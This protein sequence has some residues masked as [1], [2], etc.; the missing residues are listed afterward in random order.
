MKKL[1]VC[2][3]LALAIV[4]TL[5]VTASAAIPGVG[6]FV[7]GVEITESNASDV[8][9]DG[10]VSY[11]TK[12]RTLT[13]N[14]ASITTPYI[15]E[16]YGEDLYFGIYNS[17]TQVLRIELK[18]ENTIDLDVGPEIDDVVTGIFSNGSLEFYGEGSL[19][20]DGWGG[21]TAMNDILVDGGEYE[22]LM[23]GFSAVNGDATLKNATASASYGL[24]IAPTGDIRLENMK[25]P[26][27]G[28]DNPFY[29]E[30]G[31]ITVLD[32]E[33]VVSACMD[34]CL[35]AGE[36]GGNIN[37]KNSSLNLNSSTIAIHTAAGKVIMEGVT[38]KITAR[39]EIGYGIM[40]LGDVELSGC[41]LEI[42]ARAT[43]DSA[44]CIA[45]MGDI[46]IKESKLT[47]DAR[48]VKEP[49]TAIGNPMEGGDILVKESELD[50]NTSGWICVG[51][52]GVNIK[53]DDSKVKIMATAGTSEGDGPGG[54]MGIYTEQGLVTVEGGRLEI[55]A[56]GPLGG[57]RTSTAIIMDNALLAPI[58]KDADVILVGNVA[59][60]VAALPDLSGYASEPTVI[61]STSIDGA[62]AVDFTKDNLSSIVYIHI[63]PLYTIAFNG[64]G[65]TGEMEGEVDWYGEYTI[66]ENGFTAPEGKEFLGWAYTHEGE[67]IT[68]E[69]IFPT[70]NITLY[71][72]WKDIP[73]APPEEPENP[74]EPEH[75]HSFGSEWVMSAEE[76]YKLCE[77]GERKNVGAHTD[78]NGNGSCDICG[79]VISKGLGAGA[80]VG[81]AVGSALV[82]GV[83]GFSLVWFVFKK[84]SFADLIAVFKK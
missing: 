81:I 61:A 23:G 79:A 56:T 4:V 41:E 84:K 67:I 69:T 32:S 46:T 71:A 10:T 36:G 16:M 68:D 44:S 2:L 27:G 5:A 9:G 21:V 34:M 29:T 12:S 19:K 43:E 64:N 22:F 47:L 7:S 49:A 72:I 80:I 37:I 35:I 52:C 42:S 48:S 76:H 17:S 58:F 78:S 74:E 59:M 11:D 45:S 1:F 31:D 60:L 66:P 15:T 6:I 53:L 54:G 13:L 70:K 39:G 25:V 75:T 30:T 26:E 14:N 82:L 38:G 18:G 28:V 55:T 73:V 77:C 62:N 20:V 3:L 33:I 65:G 51:I 50:I 63:H 83:G 8:L 24:I 40:G 57:E